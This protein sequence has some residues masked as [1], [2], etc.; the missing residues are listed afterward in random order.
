M[1]IIEKNNLSTESKNDNKNDENDNENDNETENINLKNDNKV[2]ESA[3]DSGSENEESKT[4]NADNFDLDEFKKQLNDDHENNEKPVIKLIPIENDNKSIIAPNKNE[5]ENI[6]VEHEKNIKNK[7]NKIKKTFKIINDSFN[8]HNLSNIND[9]S[10]IIDTIKNCNTGPIDEIKEKRSL[11]IIIRQYVN[12]FPKELINIYLNKNVF[13]K[14]LFTLS[15]DQLKLIL[16]NI[17][18]ELNLQRNKNMFMTIA[19]NG[20]RGVETLSIFSGYDVTGL[21]EELLKDPDFIMDLEIISCEIDASKYVTPKASALLK[22]IKKG[23]ELKEKN[24]VKKN[25]D[26]VNNDPQKIEKLMNL[27]RF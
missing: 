18:L 9:R 12:T 8:N 11:I 6:N 5:N 26:I 23:Y 25:L 3:S 16:E 13:E 2:S 4:D 15:V 24:D 7:P 17:R 14:R 1:E 20:L 19:T 10:R 27:K 21:S 22:I